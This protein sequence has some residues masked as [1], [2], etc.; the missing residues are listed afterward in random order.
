MAEATGFALA[1]ETAAAFARWLET[2]VARHS[3]PLRFAEVRKGVQALSS[4]YVERRSEGRGEGGLAARASDGSAKRA[5]LA[6]FYAPLHFLVVHAATRT[7]LASAGV[8]RVHD[9]GCGTGAAGAAVVRALPAAAG[10]S[11]PSV[12][13]IDV[14]GW[15]LGEARRTWHAFGVAGRGHRGALPEAA[16][17]RLGPGDLVVLAYVLNELSPDHRTALV[18]RLGRALAAGAGL[19]VLEPLAR[20]IAP[21]WDGLVAALAPL[22]ARAAEPKATIERPPWIERLDAASGLDHRELGARVLAV[23]PAKP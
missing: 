10:E 20:R 14:S 1:P 8:R 13:G 18:G 9:F 7:M 22:G 3:P 6:T 23:P 19:L 12:L 21:W 16:P 15:A 2:C 11:A 17:E 4:L 5:A